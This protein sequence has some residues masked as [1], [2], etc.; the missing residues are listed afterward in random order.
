[1][2]TERTLE[3]RER[4]TASVFG[5]VGAI[6]LAFLYWL[7]RNG[8]ENPLFPIVATL[9]IALFILSVPVLVW[10]L[11]GA[12]DGTLDWW[13][14]QPFL[15]ILG[16]A[17]TALAGMSTSVLGEAP[18][19][20]ILIVGGTAAVWVVFRWVRD[21]GFL[22]AAGVKVFALLFFTWAGG[23][24]WSARHKHPLLM[25]A[26]SYKANVH[27]DPLFNAAVANM[28]HAYG[29][30]ST[31]VDGIPYVPYHYGASWLLAQWAD[32]AGTDV[33]TFYNMG[34]SLVMIP[35]LG[36]ALL[37]LVV[38]VRGAQRRRR[39]PPPRPL[40]LDYWAG[41]ALLAG[42][43]GVIPSAALD[44]MGVWNRHVM[45]SESYT[46]GLP[47]FLF[48]AA[49]LLVFY[50]SGP[51][52][53]TRLSSVWFVLLVLPLLFAALGLLKVSLMILTLGAVIW[54]VLRSG[55][56][57][58]PLLLAAGAVW[59]ITALV[60]YKLV[61]LPSQN[62]GLV[63]LAFMRSS[64]PPA[65]WPWFPVVHLFWSWLYVVARVRE[66]GARTVSELFAR[67][68]ERRLLDAELVAAVALAGF[69]P[70]EILEI[71][72][73][74]AIYLSDPQRWIALPLVMAMAARWIGSKT[75]GI[76]LSRVALAILAVPLLAT[77]FRNATRA[78]E[79][80]LRQNVTL[81]AQLYAQAGTAPVSWR[82]LRNDSILQRGLER[83]PRYAIVSALR[84]LS[85]MP[86]GEKRRTALFIPQSDTAFWHFF[87]EPERCNV[88]PLAGPAITGLAL[89]DGMPPLD[90]KFTDQYAFGLYS[91]RT[92]AQTDA[93][94][95]DDRLCARAVAK[96][97]S[98]LI[99]LGPPPAYPPR[100][101]SCGEAAQRR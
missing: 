58:Q 52:S 17:F 48:V 89:V 91:P 57:R 65:W 26:L 99:V 83:A 60:T 82:H 67:V 68:K 18:A 95:T 100:R 62:E 23:V 31:G 9:G 32:L 36:G 54:T 96:G 40:E 64:V 28:I 55:F 43:I 22:R 69:I 29:V 41:G 37:L 27:Q 44:A 13:R 85:A 90:C 59:V 19:W 50:D 70:G 88:A 72:G 101:L 97:F 75:P 38:E 79:T 98:R 84:R 6:V 53:R 24:A 33:L 61:A 56:W 80:A 14:S 16:V 81:R 87:P 76:R 21:V 30:P 92:V 93:D 42:T 71:H 51:P 25:E 2:E 1:M 4:A 66:E 8:F 77:L 63:P 3:L 46:T 12:R 20:V 34:P 39:K 35:V 5:I 45:I 78:P 94:L 47:V 10:W 15:A 73:G 74:S 7:A 86:R 49:L 11:A